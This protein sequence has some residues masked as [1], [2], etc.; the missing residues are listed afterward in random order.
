VK[1]LDTLML[2]TIVRVKTVGLLNDESLFILVT[3]TNWPFALMRK[4]QFVTAGI[5]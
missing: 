5:I 4:A 3:V 1:I 2:D